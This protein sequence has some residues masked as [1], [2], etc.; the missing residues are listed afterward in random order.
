MIK[1]EIKKFIIS[2]IITNFCLVYYFSNYFQN[3][4]VEAI[5][6]T[7]FYNDIF[8]FL[9]ALGIYIVGYLLFN[10]IYLIIKLIL[11]K[12][13]L[14]YSAVF[15]TTFLIS[16]LLVLFIMNDQII[17]HNIKVHS[18]VN[19]YK[20]IDD[21]KDKIDSTNFYKYNWV[22]ESIGFYRG[23]Y[24]IKEKIIFGK[25][26]SFKMIGHRIKVDRLYLFRKLLHIEINYKIVGDYVYKNCIILIDSL[27]HTYSIQIRKNKLYLNSALNAI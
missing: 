15:I 18:I 19:Y 3:S 4:I 27:H 11:R 14:K 17:I 6:N 25:N 12:K 7:F 10:I 5:K 9:F 13:S 23:K 22:K 2:F 16:I 24:L 21:Y 20:A 1:V 26:H 8:V